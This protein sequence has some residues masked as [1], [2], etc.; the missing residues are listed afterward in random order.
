MLRGLSRF[1]VYLLVHSKASQDSEF[2]YLYTQRTLKILSLF[3]RTLRGLLKFW[4]HLLILSKGL[5]RFW[6]YLLTHSKASQLK[7][8]KREPHR[9]GLRHQWSYWQEWNKEYAQKWSCLFNL[10][11]VHKVSLSLTQ[12]AWACCSGLHHSGKLPQ[13][14][15]HWA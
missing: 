8:V 3:T 4:L 7:T 12:E 5:L 14:L 10:I 13:H 15:H 2:T 1:W 11:T 6:V 9:G